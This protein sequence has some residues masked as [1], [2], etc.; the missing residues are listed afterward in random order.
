MEL[1]TIV[2]S[3]GFDALKYNVIFWKWYKMDILH[4]LCWLYWNPPREAFI[5]PYFDH[6][7]VWYGVLFVTGFVL[8]YFIFIHILIRFL[9]ETDCTTKQRPNPFLPEIN[10]QKAY[11]LAD[12]LCWFVVAGTI[13]GARLGAIFFY[14]WNYF[15]QHPSEIIKVWHG[16]LASHGGVLGVMLALYLFVKYVQTSIPQLTFLKLLDFVAIPSALVAFFIRIGNFINQEIIGTPTSL[17][18]G[19][20]FGNPAENV[21]AVPRHPVQLYEASAYLMTF[22]LLYWLW[23]KKEI[24]KKPGALVGLLFICIF[25]NR[26][27]LEFWKATQESLLNT[28]FLQVGQLLSIPFIF[29]GIILFWL[30]HKKQ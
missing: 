20:L 4:F 28:S 21:S 2:E 9:N 12:K 22:F 24:E 5:I 14:D 23:R 1:F 18:W 29:L 25:T 17:P 11:A 10:K 8:S 6:P 16:G 26:F 3:Q 19:I 13:V 15:K 27:I 30:A 7:I